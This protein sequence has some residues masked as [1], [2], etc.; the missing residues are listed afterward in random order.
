MA[1]F[2]QELFKAIYV[3][4]AIGSL[5]VFPRTSS[6]LARKSRR[7][8][9]AH[10]RSFVRAALWRGQVCRVDRDVC[11]FLSSSGHRYADDLGFGSYRSF[12]FNVDPALCLWCHRVDCLGLR[13]HVDP[14]DHFSFVTH[15]GAALA[16]VLLTRSH[17]RKNHIFQIFIK[18]L[19][20]AWVGYVGLAIDMFVLLEIGG[21]LFPEHYSWA[22][23]ILR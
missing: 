23:A 12:A 19:L 10:P 5:C 7:S 9:P 4:R 14:D 20:T 1:D 22:A 15:F 6:G 11:A 18:L 13:A 21:K 17:Y 2:L 8:R 3:Y 16:V